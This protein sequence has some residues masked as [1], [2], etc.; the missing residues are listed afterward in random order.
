MKYKSLLDWFL[1]LLPRVI[2]KYW[3]Y[4]ML[5]K[6]DFHSSWSNTLWCRLNGHPN[7]VWYHNPN[8]YEPDNRCIDCNDEL[9]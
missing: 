2:D 1:Y 5:E 9:G 4:F 3:W 7:G 8:G 6:K